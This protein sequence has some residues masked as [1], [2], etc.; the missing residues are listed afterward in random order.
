[1][2]GQMQAALLRVWNV[3]KDHVRGVLE[4]SSSGPTPE[5]TGSEPLGMG[6]ATCTT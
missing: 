1:M 4:T 5:P 6:P 3:Y 2:R